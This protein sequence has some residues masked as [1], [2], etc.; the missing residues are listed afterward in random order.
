MCRA[1]KIYSTPLSLEATP[2]TH[3]CEKGV[4]SRLGAARTSGGMSQNPWNLSSCIYRVLEFLRPTTNHYVPPW[5]KLGDDTLDYTSVIWFRPSAR[6]LVGRVKGE[7]ERRVWWLWT[8]CCWLCQNA[9]RANQIAERLWYVIFSHDFRIERVT[10][11]IVD[12]N[13]YL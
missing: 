1:C 3:T 10:R 8:A 11:F 5:L 13:Y 7:G 4:A 2:F 9:G 6:R 12:M